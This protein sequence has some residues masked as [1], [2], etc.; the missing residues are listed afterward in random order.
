MAE[1]KIK[2]TKKKKLIGKIVTYFF[3]GLIAVFL[4]LQIIGS[5]TAKNNHGVPSFFGNQTLVVLTDSMEPAIK[6]D[7]AIFIKK[8]DPKLIKASSSFEA[9]DGDVITFYRRTDGL[10]ITHRVVEILLQE[11]GS[12]RFIT[13]G[14]NLNAQTCPV[15]GCN[16]EVNYDYVYAEDILGVVI[17]HSQTIGQIIKFTSSPFVIAGVAVVPLLYVFISSIADIVKHSKMNAEEFEND[18]IDEFEVLKHQEKLKIL[19]EME[20][21]RIKE[22]LRNELADNDKEKAGDQ[23]E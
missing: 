5:I 17:G 8:I 14:D 1:V 12:Y 10:I 7:D 2:G 4:G 18:D 6:V 19:V 22:E 9:H 20:K 23:D 11:D 3:G 16:P 13:L 15:G 21:D